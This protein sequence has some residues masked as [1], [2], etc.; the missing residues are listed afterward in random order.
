MK[1][2]RENSGMSEE[3]ME[4]GRS[5]VTTVKVPEETM[6]SVEFAEVVRTKITKD[7]SCL[8]ES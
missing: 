3:Q 4:A 6:A 1:T 8:V 5:G 2:Q 7:F